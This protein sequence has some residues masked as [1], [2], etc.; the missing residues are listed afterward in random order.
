MLMSLDSQDTQDMII[1]ERKFGIFNPLAG[2]G[3]REASAYGA[4]S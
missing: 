1:I 3:G 2:F 4:F